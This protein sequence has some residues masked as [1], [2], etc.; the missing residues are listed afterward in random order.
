MFFSKT[1]SVAE[2]Q[3]LLCEAKSLQSGVSDYWSILEEFSNYGVVIC[4]QPQQLS[5]DLHL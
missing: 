4:S 2:L 5:F 1:H 3:F